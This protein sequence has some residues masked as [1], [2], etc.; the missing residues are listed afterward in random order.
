M[1]ELNNDLIDLTI[2]V[3]S[4]WNVIPKESYE[5]YNIDKRTLFLL[6]TSDNKFV[7]FMYQCKLK[8]ENFQNLY[9][10]NIDNLK[11]EGMEVLYEGALKTSG[12][13]SQVK[14]AFVS[15][16]SGDKNLRL[17]QVFFLYNNYF[18]NAS[19]EVNPNINPKDI[20]NLMDDKDVIAILKI[21]L[22]IK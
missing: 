19:T 7:S 10:D 14:Y 5:E 22:S 21:I 1:M 17:I 8:E 20:L 3:P 4:S 18:I 9:K 15:I 13:I 12:K 2:S 6:L 11:K 16:N